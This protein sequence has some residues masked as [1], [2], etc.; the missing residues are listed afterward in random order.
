MASEEMD[1]DESA[2]DIVAQLEGG[3]SLRDLVISLSLRLDSL[4]D[5]ID[6]LTLLVGQWPSNTYPT[7]PQ[8][9]QYHQP[10][11]QPWVSPNISG[12][13]YVSSNTQTAPQP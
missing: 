1:M 4:N 2:E 13:Y 10:Y 7:Y 5:K 8:Q 3:A 12:P 6:R 9:P 11:Q